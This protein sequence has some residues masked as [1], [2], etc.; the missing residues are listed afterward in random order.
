MIP[1]SNTLI[2]QNKNHVSEFALHIFTANIFTFA[3]PR[4]CLE[5]R[6]L[7]R[8]LLS[9]CPRAFYLIHMI[10]LTVK[11]MIKNSCHNSLTVDL[12][13]NSELAVIHCFPPLNH[14]QSP[15][16]HTATINQLWTHRATAAHMCPCLYVRDWI[17]NWLTFGQHIYF[18]FSI[19]PVEECCVSLKSQFDCWE[20]KGDGAFHRRS[21]TQ[22]NEEINRMMKAE[23]YWM[24]NCRSSGK[25]S[26]LHTRC[27]SSSNDVT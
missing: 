9:F 14:H 20:E 24:E 13:H 27:L 7:T 5:T 15:F 12:E 18:N 8:E 25:I 19:R 26:Q 23:N 1:R 4:Y 6:E 17:P 2:L 3:L 21:S 16:N 22:R 10:N 11:L